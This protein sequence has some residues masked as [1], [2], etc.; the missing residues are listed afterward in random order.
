[1]AALFLLALGLIVWQAVRARPLTLPPL[2]MAWTG[3]EQL[4][5]IAA[6]LW[7]GPLD[8][9]EERIERY[10]LLRERSVPWPGVAAGGACES[11][12]RTSA[13]TWVRR[14][15]DPA[16]LPGPKA[17]QDTLSYA[18]RDFLDDD[19]GDGD[20]LD[21]GELARSGDGAE[22]EIFCPPPAGEEALP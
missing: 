20:A 18:A 16:L 1:M 14:G 10:R 9:P 6:P 11:F 3:G 8:L 5:P 15:L 13:A 12:I 17:E 22:V 4:F 19:D 21:A 7:V 2:S